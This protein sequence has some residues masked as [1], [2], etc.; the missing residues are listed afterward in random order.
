VNLSS[1]LISD[2]FIVE[3]SPKSTSVLVAPSLI[4]VF[5]VKVLDLKLL[6]LAD[7]FIVKSPSITPPVLGNYSIYLLY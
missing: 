7:P 5:V 1:D 6:A 2:S 3:P 4:I